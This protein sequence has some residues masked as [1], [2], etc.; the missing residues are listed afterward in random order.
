M[1][2]RTPNPE[3]SQSISEMVHDVTRERWREDL[4]PIG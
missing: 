1:P 2:R 3:S 4:P